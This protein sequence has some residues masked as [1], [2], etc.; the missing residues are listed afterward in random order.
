M[1]PRPNP[2][3]I[4]RKARMRLPA[5][6]VPKQDPHAR[7]RNFD[8]TYLPLDADTAVQE[9]ARCIQ[10]PGALC[11]KACP[12]HNDIPLAMWH[13]EHGA[14]EGAAAVFR[15]TSTMPEVCGRVCPQVLLCEGACIYNKKELPPVPVGRLEAFVADYERLHGGLPV[16]RAPATGHST[17]VVG[18]GPAGLTVA[19]LLA[20]RGHRVT[21]F[22]GW[23]ASGGILRYGI[24]R[25]KLSHEIVDD[26]TDYL[27]A[28]GVEFEF[29]TTVGRDLTVDDLLRRGYEAVFLGTGAGVGAPFD[30]PGTE[31]RGVYAATPFLVQVNVAESQK[32]AELR[33]PADIGARV[34]VIG[35]GDTAMDCVRSAVRL[36]ADQ[37]MCV[38]RRTEAEM[39]GNVRDRAFAREEGVEFHW[40]T[41][42][43]RILGDGDGRV[44][45][46]ECIRM[47]LGEP[48]A[49]GRRRPVPIEGSTF[50]I[51][52]DTVICAL[53]Y[54]PDPLLGETTPELRTHDWGL[55]DIDEASGCTSREGVFAGGDDV[56]GPKLV[57]TAVAQARVAAEAMHAYLVKRPADP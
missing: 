7:R 26:L 54:W 44:R 32:P 20:R 3:E 5:H 36:G 42:P 15:Q 12:L 19:M 6:A 52:V 13:L 41:Q 39:P 22:E 9:A 29:C 40:L 38:Y 24:P 14:F 57:V 45:A 23:P 4:D 43:V 37:V 35:G 2:K 31:L 16:E 11:V 18:A 56:L 28:L 49:S 21:V 30:V 1:L 34:A 46:L 25:F 27:E 17:A 50:V 48:D 53:G 55:I 51:D 33:G 47:E 8:E 10:C